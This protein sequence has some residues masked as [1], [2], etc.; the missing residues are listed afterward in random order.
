MFIIK[1]ITHFGIPELRGHGVRIAACAAMPEANCTGARMGPIPNPEPAI[2]E[3]GLNRV[4]PSRKPPAIVLSGPADD[5]DLRAAAEFLSRTG[6][7][8]RSE[9][10]PGKRARVAWGADVLTDLSHARL[11]EFLWAHGAKF[12]D[13]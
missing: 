1:E 10:A 7:D 9:F 3:R 4:Q 11:V 6:L 13:S 2:T 5:S 8:Y 12:E